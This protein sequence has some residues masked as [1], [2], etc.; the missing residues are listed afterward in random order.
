MLAIKCETK[1]IID[2][3]VE[4][5]SAILRQGL[6]IFQPLS[7]AMARSASNSVNPSN[8]LVSMK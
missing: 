1:M 2:T 8:G 7:N 4:G 5:T 6:K 3:K